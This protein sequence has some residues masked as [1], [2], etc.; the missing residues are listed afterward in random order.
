MSTASHAFDTAALQ[1]Y[2]EDRLDGFAGP[3]AVERFQG[4]QSNPTYKLVTPQRCY[5]MR[6]KPAPKARLL[7][8]A[9]AIEREYA[10][11]GALHG[12]AVPVPRMLLLCEDE[13]VIGRAFYIMEFVSGRDA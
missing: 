8:S 6:S 2:L 9:H 4:G 13:S 11:M 1:A 10:V 3:L 7:P 12:S 5:V